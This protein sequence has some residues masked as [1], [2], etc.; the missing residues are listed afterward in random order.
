M[1]RNGPQPENSDQSEKISEKS[2]DFATSLPQ[3]K[4]GK[5][6]KITVID[7]RFWA[8]SS[9]KEEGTDQ[10]GDDSQGSPRKPAYVEEIE[11]KLKENETQL[12]KYIAAYK[13]HQKETTAFKDRLNKALETRLET[14]L[15]AFFRD[16]LEILDNFERSLCFAEEN[17]EFD[18]LLT[19]LKLINAQMLSLLKSQGVE[20]LERTGQHFDPHFDEV[21]EMV[22]CSEEHTAPGLIVSELQKGYVF[23]DKVLRPGKVRIVKPES[24]DGPGQ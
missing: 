5:K 11:Q 1:T 2:T 23:K 16:F 14:Q 3:E 20:P 18:G 24:G 9:P 6:P 17:K 7:K 10:G 13:D 8:R 12:R 19:G 4:D 22:P 21:I 15:A